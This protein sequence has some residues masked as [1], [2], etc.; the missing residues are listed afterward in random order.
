MAG[1]RIY[2]RGLCITV[3]VLLLIFGGFLLIVSLAYS[4]KQTIELEQ[5]DA[6]LGVLV[7]NAFGPLTVLLSIV[8]VYAAY[9]DRKWVLI[10][11]AGC[12]TVEWI[13]LIIIAVP[14][15]H[16]QPKILEDRFENVVPLY[17]ADANIQRELNKLQAWDQC[18]GLQGYSDW[19]DQIP[20][21][22]LC[23]QQTNSSDSPCQAVEIYILHNET[24]RE[25][26]E[27]H[28]HTKP[29]GPILKTHMD[30]LIQV[31]IGLISAFATIMI[32]AIVLSLVLGLEKMWSSSS[33]E[34]TLNDSSERVKHQ[35]SP[36][37]LP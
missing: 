13:A 25:T 3:N 14:L 17:N 34:A 6:S 24:R 18:C 26:Q 31:M 23:V 11:Y 2:V 12:L 19:E 20:E 33:G 15:I 27:L 36:Q 7:F 37:A 35:L 16:V 32:A 4:L 1:G 5:R 8:G 22:C 30:F 10:L 29:C 9:K 21:S 28:V